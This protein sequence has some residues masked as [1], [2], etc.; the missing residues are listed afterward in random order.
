MYYFSAALLSSFVG[1]VPL[2]LAKRF[3]SALVQGVATFFVGW[4]LF[5]TFVA[6]TVYPLF[7]FVGFMTLIWWIVAALISSSNDDEVYWPWVF[8]VGAVAF[9]LL[10]AIANSA[11][12]RADSYSSI[13]SHLG[14]IEESVWTRDIQPKDPAHMRMASEENATYQAKKVLGSAGAI[15]SQFEVGEMTVQMIGKE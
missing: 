2:L 5:Y 7:G 9:Y 1:V 13:I 10:V 12:L 15:G 14:E 6:T 8:P 4:F 11:F 3:G